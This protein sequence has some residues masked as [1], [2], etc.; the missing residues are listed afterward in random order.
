MGLWGL[1]SPRTGDIPD[2]TG[3]PDLPIRWLPIDHV[4]AV[5][6]Q[7]QRNDAI[8][9]GRSARPDP[10]H[11]T[12]YGIFAVDPGALGRVAEALEGIKEGIHGPGR[13]LLIF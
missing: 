6:G 10:L 7:A 1:E 8:L 13:D 12:S 4:G 3:E 9:Q 5:A 2:G 11:S